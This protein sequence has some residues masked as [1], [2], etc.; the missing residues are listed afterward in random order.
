MEHNICDILA[1]RMKGRKMN[2]SIKDVNN[3]AKILAGKTSK[4]ISNVIDQVCSGIVLEDKLETITEMITLTAA[5][6][7]KKVKKSKYYPT[8]QAGVPFTGQ[9]R[10]FGL[11]TE[12]FGN[13]N[14]N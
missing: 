14:L 8:Q 12:P 1:Q 11:Q 6:V 13:K 9:V 10:P 7:N 3:L 2:W 5:D 4:R